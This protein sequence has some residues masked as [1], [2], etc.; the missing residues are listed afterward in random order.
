MQ[1]LTEKNAIKIIQEKTNKSKDYSEAWLYIYEKYKPLIISRTKNN[2]DHQ[3]DIFL[4]IPQIV[5]CYDET[6]AKFPQYM[7]ICVK[8]AY[9]DLIRPEPIDYV[10]PYA[11]ENFPIFAKSYEID[12]NINY[13]HMMDKI[14]SVP[15]SELWIRHVIGKETY[16]QIGITRF[17]YIKIHK[18]IIALFRK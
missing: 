17:S 7:K 15:G 5:K 14:K 9:I 2:E 16:A 12:S 13:N 6:R 11:L 10:E 8:N 1:T 4:K 18:K 3:H